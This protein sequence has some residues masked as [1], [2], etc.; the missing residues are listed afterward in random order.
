MLNINETTVT[1]LTNSRIVRP[2]E[3]R[4]INV[5]TNGDQPIHHDQE[6][7]VQSLRKS[8]FPMNAYISNVSLGSCCMQFPKVVVKE[9]IICEVEPNINTKSINAIARTTLNQLKYR[10]PRSTPVVVEN[11]N[12]TVTTKITRR[13]IINVSEN[14]PNV[15]L[16][17]E[18]F[19]VAPRPKDVEIPKTGA[20]TANVSI[21]VP[22]PPFTRLPSNGAKVEL[23]KADAL[24]RNLKY[25]NAKA[26]TA[27]V[28][29]G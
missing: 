5:P 18:V 29:Q 8:R 28:A 11:I 21:A 19:Y 15:Q 17:P 27:Y 9:S 25:A 3:T 24:C 13:F 7:S 12:S 16:S 2:L 1:P 10:I 6:N 22:N 4:A 14:P 26:T 23:M 20:K